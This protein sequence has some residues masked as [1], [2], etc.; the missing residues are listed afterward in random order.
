MP[1]RS[2]FGPPTVAVDRP[3][4][5]V[6]SG[7]PTAM[8]RVPRLRDHRR[9]R[10]APTNGTSRPIRAP[11][12]LASVENVDSAA[13][14]PSRPVPSNTRVVALTENSKRA[15]RENWRFV[16]IRVQIPRAGYWPRA[17]RWTPWMAMSSPPL[18]AQDHW[19]GKALGDLSLRTGPALRRRLGAVGDCNPPRHDSAT[20]LAG[21]ATA[22]L[23]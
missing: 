19:C 13:C 5:K 4:Q 6:A 17:V 16:S 22:T 18:G 11:Y 20:A 3:S 2:S 10:R 8:A 1:Q 14:N 7:S 23:R 15:G 12:T 21:T 9:R